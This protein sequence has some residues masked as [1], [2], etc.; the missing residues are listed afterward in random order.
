VRTDAVVRDDVA[1]RADTAPRL[2]V[3]AREEVPRPLEGVLEHV[4]VLPGELGDASD[5][6]T[7]VLLEPFDPFRGRIDRCAVVA[8]VVGR[9]RTT[10]CQRAAGR[11]RRR[12]EHRPTPQ[13]PGRHVSSITRSVVVLASERP[14]VPFRAIMVPHSATIV[15]IL[16]P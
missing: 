13:F 14:F 8:V 15:L 9:E 4:D 3:D 6:E 10:P 12:G 5:A 2:P 16:N 7:G 1:V 11:R